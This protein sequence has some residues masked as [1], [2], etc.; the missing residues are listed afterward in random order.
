MQEFYTGPQT[1][2]SGSDQHGKEG[3]E[4]N[5]EFESG[6]MAPALKAPRAP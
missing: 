1:A 4:A 6:A 5:M 3:M 2:G